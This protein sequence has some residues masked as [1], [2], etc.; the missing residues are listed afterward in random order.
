MRK[1]EKHILQKWPKKKRN[2]HKIQ[3]KG[4]EMK[5]IKGKVKKPAK[6]CTHFII[7]YQISRAGDIWYIYGSCYSSERHAIDGATRIPNLTEFKLIEFKL[8]V[9]E[10]LY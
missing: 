4:T 3:T 10:K 7:L 9:G 8:P 1:K 2:R 6:E 5:T